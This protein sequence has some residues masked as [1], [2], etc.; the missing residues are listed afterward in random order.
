MKLLSGAILL[1]ASEQAFAHAQLAQFPYHE[2]AVIVLIP[3]AVVFAALGT[4]LL[5]WGLL[6]EARRKAGPVSE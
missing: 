4:L 3:A 6:T 1:H 2:D 5:A